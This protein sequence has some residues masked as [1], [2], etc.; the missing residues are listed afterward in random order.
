MSKKPK[1]TS[2]AVEVD[3]ITYGGGAYIRRRVIFGVL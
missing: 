1:C 3:G 2:S